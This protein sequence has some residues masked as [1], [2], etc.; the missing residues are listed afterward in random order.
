MKPFRVY[1]GDALWGVA[2]LVVHVCYYS[3][4]GLGAVQSWFKR[5]R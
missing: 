3:L 4:Q 2:W 5:E 1:V